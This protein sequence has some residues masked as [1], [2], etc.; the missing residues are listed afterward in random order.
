M[1]GLE[2]VVATSENGVVVSEFVPGKHISGMTAEEVDEITHEQLDELVAN[3]IAAS[4][5]GVKFDTFADNTLYDKDNGFT[6][7]DYSLG[8]TELDA[9]NV[10]RTIFESLN[11]Y[12]QIA[13][14]PD[15]ERKL[16]LEATNQAV[17]RLIGGYC[18]SRFTDQF[19]SE[20][21]QRSQLARAQSIASA[22]GL[23]KQ[24]K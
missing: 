19:R 4:K 12:G 15:P 18:K 7:I 13:V 5:R 21:N 6:D 16:A 9:S 8:G 24:G 3:R 2:Q 1:A 23:Q 14:E 22:I 17:F 10:M 11:V 20:L